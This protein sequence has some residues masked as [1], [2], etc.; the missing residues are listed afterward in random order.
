[1]TLPT[2]PS[3]A[4]VKSPSSPVALDQVSLTR[5]VLTTTKELCAL[6]KTQTRA[7]LDMTEAIDALRNQLKDLGEII[8][9]ANVSF[10]PAD[11]PPDGAKDD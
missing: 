8:T 7:I 1:M 9:S 11:D 4:P 3:P 2:P 10:E 6:M 5:E